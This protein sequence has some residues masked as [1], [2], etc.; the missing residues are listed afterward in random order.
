MRILRLTAG[1]FTES[2]SAGRFLFSRS[3]KGPAAEVLPHYGL[4][5]REGSEVGAAGVGVDGLDDP[6]RDL[7]A[8]GEAS[9][10]LKLE[11]SEENT[12]RQN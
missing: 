10:F 1:G 12:Q 2:N 6:T 8:R 7:W 3:V 11:I 4:E 9:Y 5:A